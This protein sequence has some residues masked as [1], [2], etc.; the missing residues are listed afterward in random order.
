[1]AP[2]GFEGMQDRVLIILVDTNACPTRM[3]DVA[4]LLPL[5]RIRFVNRDAVAALMQRLDQ[6]AVVGRGAVPVSGKHT[7]NKKRNLHRSTSAMI[8]ISSSTRW[9]QVCRAR[10]V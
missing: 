5:I 4:V 6:A 2:R 9:A 10:T 1:M 3:L 7:R 8:D